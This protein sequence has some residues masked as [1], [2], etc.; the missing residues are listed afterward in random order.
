MSTKINV[1]SPFYIKRTYTSVP[2]LNYATMELFIYTGE[3]GTDKPASAQYTV[4]KT[5]LSDGDYVVFEISELIRDYLVTEYGD[6]STEI[7]WV[8]ADITAY[9]ADGSSL[10]TVSYDYLA[11][12]G[13]GYF[14]DGIN[15]QLETQLLQ[16]NTALYYNEGEDIVLAVW[17]EDNPYITFQ[18]SGG[19]SIRWDVIDEYW[20][21]TSLSWGYGDTAIQ[22]LDS[23]NSADKIVYVRI[24]GSEFF[25]SNDTITIEKGIGGAGGDAIVISLVEICEPKYTPLNVIFYNKFGALQNMWFFKRSDTS[26]NVQSDSYKSNILDLS[27]LSYSTTSHQV[28]SFNVNGNETITLNSGFYDEDYNEVIRQLLLSEQIWID[29]GTNVLPVNPNTNSYRFQKNVNDKLIQHTLEF[30]YAY[31]KINNVR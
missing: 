24:S 6:Y 15:P 13:Y 1:R 14:E 5:E 9:A 12:D 19:T 21:T 20:E 25:E 28:Q 30:S 4:T 29:N 16:S 27:T 18:T 26:I 10:G 3:F 2:T 8:E 17:A 22:V 23:T 31:D 11:M 7:V